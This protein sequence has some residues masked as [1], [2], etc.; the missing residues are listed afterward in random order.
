M[1]NDLCDT[2]AKAYKG[3][4]PIWPTLRSTTYCV[5]YIKRGSVPTTKK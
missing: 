3:G 1:K 5:E 4:C 2:C